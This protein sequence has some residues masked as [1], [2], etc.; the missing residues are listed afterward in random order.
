[1]SAIE[2]LV[3]IVPT[4]GVDEQRRRGAERAATFLSRAAVSTAST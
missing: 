1:M 3:Q 4:L 2:E